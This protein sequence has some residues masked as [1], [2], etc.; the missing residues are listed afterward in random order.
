MTARAFKSD[1]KFSYTSGP[2]KCGQSCTEGRELVPGC[3][4]S[5]P[6][7]CGLI[8]NSV[9]DA[10]CSYTF[11][12]NCGKQGYRCCRD[13]NKGP[14]CNPRI[15]GWILDKGQNSTFQ[16]SGVY[17]YDHC[18]TLCIRTQGC[19]HWNWITNESTMFIGGAC[20]LKTYNPVDTP[21][22]VLAMPHL[23]SVIG[24]VDCLKDYGIRSPST[25]T[26]T[27]PTG[28]PIGTCFESMIDI[29]EGLLFQQWN[30]AGPT[31]CQQLCQ[32]W[33]GCKFF[34]YIPRD[35]S[36]ALKYSEFGR[37]KVTDL[38]HDFITGP[39]D[40][41]NVEPAP[42]VADC[43][44]A[45]TDIDSKTL[46]DV[47][48][49]HVR[50]CYD[51]CSW[52]SRCQG[53]SYLNK[54]CYLKE[55]ATPM[56][57][58]PGAVSGLQQC[59][60]PQHEERRTLTMDDIIPSTLIMDGCA[61]KNKDYMGADLESIKVESLEDCWKIC[62]EREDCKTFSVSVDGICKIKWGGQLID[63]VS[64][65]AMPRK[66]RC[67]GDQCRKS[68]PDFY[69]HDR[70]LP[71]VAGL[72][73]R[74]LGKPD[75]WTIKGKMINW[76]NPI[77]WQRMALLVL[78]DYDCY[79]SDMISA[80]TPD[81]W[82]QRS[83]YFP[84]HMRVQIIG[85]SNVTEFKGWSKIPWEP[86]DF[87]SFEDDHFQ[88]FNNENIIIAESDKANS[89]HG[90]FIQYITNQSFPSYW[91]NDMIIPHNFQNG[92]FYSRIQSLNTPIPISFRIIFCLTG[93]DD[94]VSEICTT[95]ITV[96]PYNV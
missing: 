14:C 88:L 36:C 45:D 68:E 41:P 8:G 27:R 18:H 46:R 69:G 23:N 35:R 20:Y 87:N 42:P 55:S 85:V 6:S 25:D 26:T 3:G 57:K 19:T 47:A 78:T 86:K 89:D 29:V 31:A 33:P 93:S 72:S 65:I 7:S 49:A 11:K 1:S 38:S 32:K 44:T 75:H 90:V 5:S 21:E 82:E 24:A 83:N 64:S 22:F 95:P 12:S 54:R 60:W 16:W 52:D 94:P 80:N 71:A 48:S 4:A 10:T 84:L 76:S 17:S 67:E 15:S 62:L 73:L 50:H 81:C 40:C 34:V 43:I 91:P 39:R 70:V 61:H 58:K 63:S 77:S 37:K 79:V 28:V 9:F 74:S 53:W 56:I 66:C 30:I 13:C 96:P 2:R 59:T 92:T 51:Q